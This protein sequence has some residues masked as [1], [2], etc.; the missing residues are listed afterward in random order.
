MYMRPPVK[1]CAYQ[2]NVNTRLFRMIAEDAGIIAHGSYPSSHFFTVL[3]VCFPEPAGEVFF[4]WYDDEDLHHEQQQREQYQVPPVA[5]KT[6]QA[7]I[8]DGQA[9]IHGIARYSINAGCLQ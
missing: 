3:Q 9:R 6:S 7:K 8:Q 4:F 2:G 1:G 5:K